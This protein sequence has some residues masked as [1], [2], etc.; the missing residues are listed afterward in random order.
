MFAALLMTKGDPQ[1]RDFTAKAYSESGQYP[2]MIGH[3][4]WEGHK[5]PINGTG[6]EALNAYDQAMTEYLA[7]VG[8]PGGALV[9]YYQGKKV[10]A[11]GFGSADLFM[12]IPF[13]AETPSRISSLSKYLTKQAI[14][15]L[16]EQGK[17]KPESKAIDVLRR[18]GVKPIGSKFDHRIEKITIQN[19]LDHKSGIEAGLDIQG[20]MSSIVIHQMGF[21]KPISQEDALSYVLSRPLQSE[22]GTAEQYSNYGYSLL[23]K[24][25]QIVSGQSYESYVK[26]KVLEPRVD[27]SQWFVTNSQ[28]KDKRYQEP[29]YYSVRSRTWDVF[30]WDICAGAGGWVAPV[31]G[32]AEFFSKEFPGPGY[33][34]T[35]FGS[36][37][38]AVTVAKVHK[39]TLTFAASINFRRGN[40][41]ADNDVLFRKLEKVTIGLKLP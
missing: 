31:D 3:L 9:V 35:Q 5:I 1:E 7:E 36:Y 21:A 19:L 25:V 4:R 32:I 41:A 11:K 30:R 15:N 38:G 14:R 12:N 28:R 20:C 27:S 10:Y 17:L 33:D 40:D 29:E 23:G 18:G 34:F 26:S 6:T 37:S 16:I 22:P 39:N 24:I 2:E 13:T 8:A